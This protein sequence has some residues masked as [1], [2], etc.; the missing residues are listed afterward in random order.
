[1]RSVGV[2]IAVPLVTDCLFE[3]HPLPVRIQFVRQKWGVPVSECESD[4]I[5]AH[6]PTKRKAGYGE[7]AAAASKLPVP[8]KEDLQYK[9]SSAWRYIGKGATSYDLAD[10]CTGKAG[11]GMDA[12]LEA[13]ETRPRWNR[14]GRQSNC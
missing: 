11:V 2:L 9:P 1:M 12:H 14:T 5:M 6:R 7:L 8:K 10:V 13:V 4:K 3:F